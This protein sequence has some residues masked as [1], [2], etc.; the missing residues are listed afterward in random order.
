MKI[1]YY[2]LISFFMLVNLIAIYIFIDSKF[3][4]TGLKTISIVDFKNLLI[5][6]II[7]IVILFIMNKNKKN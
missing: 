5:F 3:V 1:I 2:L 4:N 6:N 7:L